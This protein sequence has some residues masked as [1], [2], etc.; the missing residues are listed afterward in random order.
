MLFRWSSMSCCSLHPCHLSMVLPAEVSRQPWSPA[1]YCEAVPEGLVKRDGWPSSPRAFPRRGRLPQLLTTCASTPL[2]GLHKLRCKTLDKTD[3]WGWHQEYVSIT[4]T[5][6]C[7][8]WSPQHVGSCVYCTQALAFVDGPFTVISLQ[9]LWQFS[10]E[11]TN[12][13]GLKSSLFMP[14]WIA[15]TD[16]PI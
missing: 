2:S 5:H 8:H 13:S 10:K 4:G 9:R 7:R 3:F 14:T 6:V 15:S 1:G 11:N 12:V 16:S